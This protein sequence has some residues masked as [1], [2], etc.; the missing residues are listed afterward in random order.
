MKQV[1]F[2]DDMTQFANYLFKPQLKTLGPK[3]GKRLGEIRTALAGLDG[4]ASTRP[5]PAAM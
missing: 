3:Y 2:T 1:A 5:C 4:A